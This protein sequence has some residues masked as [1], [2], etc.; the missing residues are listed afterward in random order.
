MFQR[1]FIFQT[2]IYA[3]KE[4]VDNGDADYAAYVT[5]RQLIA[6]GDK[7]NIPYD[8]PKSG[9]KVKRDDLLPLRSTLDFQQ[10]WTIKLQHCMWYVISGELLNVSFAVLFI[11]RLETA[12]FCLQ[13]AWRA[14]QPEWC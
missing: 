14:I 10:T 6:L 3:R 8:L 1:L 4:A 12:P 11:V 7:Y 2:R 13:I 9:I 5:P